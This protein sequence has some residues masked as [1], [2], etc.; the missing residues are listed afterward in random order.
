MVQSYPLG[1]TQTERDRLLAQAEQYAPTTSW[2]LDQIG[3]Q[4][5]W[6]T[7]DIGCGPIGILDLLSQ[8]VGPTGAVV[9]LEREPRFVEMA[10]AEINGRGLENVTIVQADGLNTGLD[11]GSFDLVHERLVLINVSARETFLTEMLSLLRPGGTIALQDV[12]NV[13]W[14][15][16]PAHPSWDILLN[17]FHTVF[18][19]GGGDPFIGRRLPV[20]LRAAGVQ[21]IQTKVT[22]ATPPP[23]DYRRTHL[24]SLI[25]SIRDKVIAKGV[26]DEAKLNEHRQALA[27][28]LEDPATTVID[29][30]LLQCWGQKSS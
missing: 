14:L 29:K 5:G 23:G 13:S 3:I 1:G 24:I 8:R 25:D 9:G 20:L 2:L 30:L 15:C 21:N 7:V 28:H 11:K 26:L 22:V 4:P 12:D 17:A 16:Q 6:R 19:A 10:R 27:R 18:H